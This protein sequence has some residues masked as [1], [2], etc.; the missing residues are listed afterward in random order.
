MNTALHGRRAAADRTG[1]RAIRAARSLVRDNPQVVTA[2]CAIFLA[3]IAAGC[4]FYAARAYLMPVVCAFVM[5]VLLAPIASMLEARGAP[6]TLA[7]ILP[8]IGLCALFYVAG[9]LVAAPAA[10]W[11]ANAPEIMGAAREHLDGIRETVETVEEI[12]EGME[13][14]AGDAT[15]REVVVQGPGLTQSLATSASTII[16]QALFVLVVT[17]FFLL[18]RRDLRLKLIAS[19]ATLGGRLNMA[20]IFCDIERR[21]GVYI[22]TMSVVNIGLG[23]AVA[24]AMWALG[25]ESP[26]MWGGLAAALNFVPYVGP[27]ILTILLGAA[28]LSSFDTLGGALTPPAAYIALNFIESNLVTPIAVG[29]R[30][31]LNPLA[32]LIAVSFWT[33][34][35][36]PLG[37]L[38]SIPM[39]VM[40]KV[41]LDRSHP[42]KALG[43][44]IGGPLPGRRRGP[45]AHKLNLGLNRISALFADERR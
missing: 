28:G 10:R 33:W 37:G 6:R 42:L 19:R 16:V 30:M 31:T 39:L 18:T 13:G 40:L 32:I 27:A 12:S 34:L 8:V 21:V 4:V 41:V 14:L 11:L 23:V 45:G 15:S 2:W 9:L 44:F 20:R 17:Y 36:G 43:A 29:R 22:A 24:L 7:A 26:I 5:S 35:W 3:L 1:P 25:V 38:L